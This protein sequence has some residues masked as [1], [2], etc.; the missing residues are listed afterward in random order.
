VAFSCGS[1]RSRAN[2]ARLSSSCIS[3]RSTPTASAVCLT[4][5]RLPIVRLRPNECPFPN[6]H[7][8]LENP[9]PQPKLR[10]IEKVIVVPL[11]LFSAALHRSNCF[12]RESNCGPPDQ[13]PICREF[14]TPAAVAGAVETVPNRPSANRPEARTRYR[15]ID[16]NVILV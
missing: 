3:S 6:D 5:K 1:T 7:D 13:L 8:G 15:L 11:P 2:N 9:S 14:G 10:S 12:V 16:P 4:W